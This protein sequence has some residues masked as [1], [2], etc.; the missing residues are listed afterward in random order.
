M[1]APEDG[2]W[3]MVFFKGSLMRIVYSLALGSNCRI[4]YELD[5]GDRAALTLLVETHVPD[6]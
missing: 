2:A 1:R 5:W 6:P 4:C 3:A